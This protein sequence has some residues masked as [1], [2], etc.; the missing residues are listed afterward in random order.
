MQLLGPHMAEAR[1]VEDD[2]ADPMMPGDKIFSPTL[3]AG[4]RR[5]FRP[6]RMIDIDGDGESDRQRVHDLI[7]LNGG[8][9]D[10]EVTEAGKMTAKL[11]INTKYLV[12]GNEPQ[13]RQAVTPTAKLERSPDARRADHHQSE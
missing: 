5:A 11:S 9:I 12:L 13:R 8:V 4:P 1:I 3:G 10:A 2:L 7:R 6:G